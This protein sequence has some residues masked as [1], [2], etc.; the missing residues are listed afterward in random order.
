MAAHILPRQILHNWRPSNGHM[1]PQ[2]LFEADAGWY[3]HGMQLQR[4]ARAWCLNWNPLAQAMDDLDDWVAAVLPN[5]PRGYVMGAFIDVCGRDGA[6]NPIERRIGRARTL[7]PTGLRAAHRAKDPRACG[8]V[9]GRSWSRSP[10]CAC[11][12]A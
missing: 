10:T 6:G 12:C 11:L 4:S 9:R 7:V 5:V 3:R 8:G 2:G 1:P